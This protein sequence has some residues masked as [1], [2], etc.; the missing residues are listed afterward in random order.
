MVIFV[1]AITQLN[2]IAVC[3]Q[4]QIFYRLISLPIYQNLTQPSH[5]EPLPYSRNLTTKQDTADLA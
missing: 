1:V 4:K 3:R 5:P 2:D